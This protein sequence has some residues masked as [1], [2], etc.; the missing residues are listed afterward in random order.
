MWNSVLRTPGRF[1]SPEI[2][3]FRCFTSL[4]LPM[5]LALL[6][7]LTAGLR[8]DFCWLQRYFIKAE[9]K[10]NQNLSR[11]WSGSCKA[12]EGCLPSVSFPFLLLALTLL[13]S[14]LQ[15]SS[16]YLMLILY[17]QSHEGISQFMRTSL[18]VDRIIRNT[19]P[20]LF[21]YIKDSSVWRH[22]KCTI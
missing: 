7:L 8:F 9:L 17:V 16:E 2:L 11:C 15:I 14:S 22:S 13:T 21:D 20:N 1:C 10:L 4:T 3:I 19:C 5:L 18:L 12:E 6:C